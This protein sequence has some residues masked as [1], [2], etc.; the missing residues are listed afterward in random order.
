[1]SDQETGQAGQ[2]TEAAPLAGQPGAEQVQQDQTATATDETNTTDEAVA[3]SDSPEGGDND[4]KRKSRERRERRERREHKL[5]VENA[6]LTE[7]LR[8]LEEQRQTRTDGN[9]QTGDKPPREADYADYF[10]FVKADA[11]FH[12]RKAAREEF[13]ALNG[14]SQERAAREEARSTQEAYTKRLEEF[15]KSAPDFVEVMEDAADTPISQAMAEVIQTSERGPAL[16]YHLAKHPDIALRL[17]KMSPLAAASE[18]GQIEER[19]VP[20]KARTETSAPKPIKPLSGS[21]AGAK[22]PN[23][24]STEEYV[25]WRKA[26]GGK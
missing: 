1:M 5:A 25:A 20:V 23:D 6:V 19:L 24:M 16:V 12:A 9:T 26:G 18:L 8:S 15:K 3:E 10:E 21:F 22:N 11:T 2:V 7:R 13:E 14:S 17:S 4:E